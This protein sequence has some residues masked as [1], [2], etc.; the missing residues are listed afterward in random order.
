L[1]ILISFQIFI[2]AVQT[3]FKFGDGILLFPT[4]DGLTIK[5]FNITKTAAGEFRFVIDFFGAIKTNDWPREKPCCR[6]MIKHFMS[7][8]KKIETNKHLDNFV[9]D[10]DPNAEKLVIRVFL[11]NG[12]NK[13]YRLPF[14]DILANSLPRLVQLNRNSGYCIGLM[15]RPLWDALNIAGKDAQ[16]VG[17]EFN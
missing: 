10:M 2:G 13:L 14:T 11:K 15:A 5:A 8:L 4:R 9:L 3:L 12:I 17:L 1:L 6:V 7:V 16:E